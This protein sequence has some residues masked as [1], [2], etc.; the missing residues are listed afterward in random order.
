MISDEVRE[1]M[2]DI[3]KD[4]QSGQFAR[5]WMEEYK[6]GGKTFTAT[7]LSEQNHPIE[8]VGSQLR[9]AFQWTN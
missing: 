9:E 1:N 7:R 3:L 4:I 2:N 5:D 8:H 6:N